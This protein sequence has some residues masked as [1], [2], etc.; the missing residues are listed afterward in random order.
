M[1]SF[2]EKLRELRG[3]RSLA[4]VEAGCGVNRSDVKAYEDDKYLPKLGNFRKLGQY[5]EAYE[6]L[7]PLYL[8][9]MFPDA[10]EQDLIMKWARTRGETPPET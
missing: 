7:F 2:G 6:E 5:Y 8:E 3:D 1:G 4:K 9:E 10:L